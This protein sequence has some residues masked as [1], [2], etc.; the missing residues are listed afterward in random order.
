MGLRAKARFTGFEELSQ[1]RWTSV[2]HSVLDKSMCN[3]VN[4]IYFLRQ[5]Q[6]SGQYSK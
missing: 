3:R 1:T 2:N 4:I 5:Y 6:E